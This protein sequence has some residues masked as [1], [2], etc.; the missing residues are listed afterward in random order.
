MGLGAAVVFAAMAAPDGDA[1][2]RFK[3]AQDLWGGAAVLRRANTEGGAGTT[4]ASRVNR[5]GAL[6]VFDTDRALDEVREA[7]SVGVSDTLVAWARHARLGDECRLAS[8]RRAEFVETAHLSTFSAVERVVVH[9][10][11]GGTTLIREGIAVS[12]AAPITADIPHAVVEAHAA[13]VGVGRQVDTLAA[14]V[15][16]AHLALAAPHVADLELVVAYV[17]AC[18]AVAGVVLQVEALV[19]ALALTGQTHASAVDAHVAVALVAARTAVVGI[20]GQV[21][22]FEPAQALT[23]CTHTHTGVAHSAVAAVPAGPAVVGVVLQI[24]AAVEAHRL[25]HRALADTGVAGLVRPAGEA[26]LTTVEWVGS[27]DRTVVAALDRAHRAHADAGPP[28]AHV[29]RVAGVV[30]HAAVIGVR[31]GA[32]T[33]QATQLG[34]HRAVR[35]AHAHVTGLVVRTLDVA[36][37][38]VPRVR[39]QVETAVFAQDQ[40]V[41]AVADP[42]VAEPS[43]AAVRLAAAAVRGIVRGIEATVGA[44]DQTLRAV[45]VAGQARRT[46][47]AVEVARS[48]VRRVVG[49][50]DA[51]LTAL[52][53]AG[54]ATRHTAALTAGLGVAARVATRTAVRRVGVGIDARPPAARPPLGAVVDACS[55]IACLQRAAGGVTAAAMIGVVVER[56]THFAAE[57]LSSRAGPSGFAPA[58]VCAC[59]GSRAFRTAGLHPTR[60]RTRTCRSGPP[61]AGVGVTFPARRCR[62]IR[63]ARGQRHTE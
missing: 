52:D 56:H 8:T 11:A 22:A 20:V 33:L 2:A 57:L 14:A 9:A 48:T 38:A 36:A 44:E 1:I 60:G 25:A 51:S 58:R 63:T 4:D 18:A 43:F 3:V 6:T 40:T 47:T 17:S 10:G 24:D 59:G 26:A 49:D 27:R 28:A 16:H 42:R 50:V 61:G 13:V 35:H 21:G 37:A 62:G 23:G 30:A 41:L 32:H 53:E 54:V 55:G 45:A 12:L 31:I 5:L 39:G 19:A 34:A 29:S 15:G 7:A 46:N